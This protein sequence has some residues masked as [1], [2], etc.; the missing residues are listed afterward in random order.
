MKECLYTPRQ[1]P[2]DTSSMLVVLVAWNTNV[3]SNFKTMF[4][5][6]SADVMQEYLIIAMIKTNLTDGLL[7]QL[8]PL[9]SRD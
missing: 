7:M 2:A 1:D 3:C 9:K 8:A 4:T 6:T 5:F